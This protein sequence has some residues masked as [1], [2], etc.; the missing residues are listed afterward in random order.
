MTRVLLCWSSGKDS[1]WALNV[2]RRTPGVEV[3]ALLTTFNSQFDRVAMHGVR[4]D[5][6]RLQAASARLPLWEIDLPSPCANADYESRMSQ[7]CQ[8]ALD[9]G[10]QS[11]AFGDL[12]LEDVRQYREAQLASTGLNAR[13]PL[14]GTPTD[15]L[16]REMIGSGQRA[17]ISCVDSRQLPAEFCGR[18]FDEPFLMD[19]PAGA[20]PC[21]ENGEFHSFVYESPVFSERIAIETGELV[22]RDGFIYADVL[23]V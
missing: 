6:V 1:A 19:L 13:F 23:P 14:W 8:R 17:R 5:L 9:A 10:I 4:R 16:A 21:G 11:I 7:A 12:F 20:D 15:L 3:A 22:D 2:L 18:D